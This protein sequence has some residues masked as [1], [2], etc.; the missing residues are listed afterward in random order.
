MTD[1][2]AFLLAEVAALMADL[3]TAKLDNQLRILNGY[4]TLNYPPHYFA[5]IASD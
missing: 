3:E 5:S 4:T 1:N 2:S